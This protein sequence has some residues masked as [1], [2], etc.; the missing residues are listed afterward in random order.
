MRRTLIAMGAAVL[1]AAPGAAAAAPRIHQLVV[2]R[3]GSFKEKTVTAGRA[4]VNVNRRRCAVAP[5]TPLAALVRSRPPSL[6]LRDYGSCSKRARDGAGLFVKRIGGDVN[7]GQD[8]WV[9]KVGNRSGSAGAADPT[10]PF[11]NGR[12]RRGARVVWFYCHMQGS[13][14]QRTPS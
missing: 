4:S 7:A 12:L 5:A 6:G 10:G 2:F 11:G 1:V 9:Y 8:G 13:T 3:N 14:C